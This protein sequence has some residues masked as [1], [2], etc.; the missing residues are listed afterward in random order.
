[1]Q[2]GWWDTGPAFMGR[3]PAP[4]FCGCEG[5]RG[6]RFHALVETYRAEFDEMMGLLSSGLAL[7]LVWKEPAASRSSAGGSRVT[8]ALCTS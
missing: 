2:R 8:G 4:G 7:L 3:R 5:S 1:M 6:R